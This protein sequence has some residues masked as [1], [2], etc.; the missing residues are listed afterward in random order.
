MEKV[1]TESRYL[2]SPKIMSQTFERVL[3]A[4]LVLTAPNGNSSTNGT[5]G[6]PV[7]GWF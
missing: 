6:T 1:W 5:Y 3:N 7:Y 2:F 4:S